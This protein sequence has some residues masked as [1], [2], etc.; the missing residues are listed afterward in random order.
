MVIP[1]KE[2]LHLLYYDEKAKEMVIREGAT[3]EQ[4]RILKEFLQE[5]KVENLS[6]VV[7]E[8]NP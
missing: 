7:I 5:V 2:I 8:L 6:D 3:E 1:P 4:K